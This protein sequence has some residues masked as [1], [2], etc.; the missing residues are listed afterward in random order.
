VP[1]P[2]ARST[3]RAQVEDFEPCQLAVP[4]SVVLRGGDTQLSIR[5]TGAGT[6]LLRDARVI[7]KQALAFVAPPRFPLR[8]T[9]APLALALKAVPIASGSVRLVPLGLVDA[10]SLPPH[11]PA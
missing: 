4:D 10:H 7:S 2:I 8:L 3:V 6:C 11:G 9:A 5:H 1:P